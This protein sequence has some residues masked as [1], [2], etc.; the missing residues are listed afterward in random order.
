MLTPN[1]EGHSQLHHVCFPSLHPSTS[2]G[3]PPAQRMCKCSKCLEAKVIALIFS[4]L[5][6]VNWFDTP[7]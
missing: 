7:A 1:L 3:A 5:L 6:F 4:K 2:Q